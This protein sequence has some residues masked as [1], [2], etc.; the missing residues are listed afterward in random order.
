MAVS[1]I[2]PRKELLA[3]LVL[4]VVLA[5]VIALMAFGKPLAGVPTPFGIDLGN[6]AI[7]AGDAM[8]VAAVIW[9]IFTP[10]AGRE[11]WLFV[12]STIVVSAQISNFQSRTD[13]PEI[14]QEC[15]IAVS[16]VMAAACVHFIARR[17]L[18]GG[19]K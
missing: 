1:D 4:G 9:R 12:F 5:A 14:V 17:L 16:A 15:G 3:Q 10:P 6:A 8:L 18:A 19:A 11:L 2:D 13:H 7:L